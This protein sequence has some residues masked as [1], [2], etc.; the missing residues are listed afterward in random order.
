MALRID[1][2]TFPQPGSVAVRDALNV[3][4]RLLVR[5]F[6]AIAPRV[7]PP[8]SLTRHVQVRTLVE[9]LVRTAPRAVAD[10]LREPPVAGLIGALLRF[11]RQGGPVREAALRLDELDL[12]VLFG[13]AVRGTLPEPVV[14]PRGPL[15][16]PVLRSVEARLE[17]AITDAQSLEFRAGDILVD[18]Q[19]LGTAARP[20]YVPVTPYATLA[21]T[22]NNPL[23]DKQQHPE[24]QG[25]ALDLGGRTTEEWASALGEAFAILERYL[26]EIVAEMRLVGVLVVP[27]GF[28]P[29]RHFSC[30]YEDLPGVTYLSLHPQ[31]VKLAEALVHEFQ[32]NKLNLV[33][34]A[35]PL[36]EDALEARY[37][38]PV[39]PDPRHLHGVLMAVHAFQPV[40]LLYD[41]M[42]EAGD[43]LARG[44]DW[45]R[46]FAEVVQTTREGAETV[47]THA[48]PTSLG[49]GLLE[50]LRRIDEQLAALARRRWPPST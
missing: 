8:E 36:L 41:R 6:L 25:N 46:R 21:L 22:D 26:P 28:A 48:R 33:F 35:D 18:G 10:V 9:R 1:D 47:L 43:A 29:E 32:H 38:S 2:L 17:V 20:G 42:T 30:S 40:A 34:R 19:S 27:V 24:R 50:E 31:P 3:A 11:Q 16:W 15:P 14:V 45:D 12:L 23:A 44:R 7:L 49:V 13:L 4:L 5:D 39:R 37:Q